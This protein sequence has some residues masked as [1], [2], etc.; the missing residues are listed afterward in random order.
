MPDN[1]SIDEYLDLYINF[2]LKVK[3]AT[4]LGMDTAEAYRKSLLAIANNWLNLILV[5]KM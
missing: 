4:M 5:I 3:E 1:K 2:K